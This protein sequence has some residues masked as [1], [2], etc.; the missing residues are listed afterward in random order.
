MLGINICFSSVIYLDDKLFRYLAITQCDLKTV[1]DEF[2]KKPYA[3]AV[4]KGSPLKDQLN[5]A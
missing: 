1:G 5:D 3:L 2:N 4:Q